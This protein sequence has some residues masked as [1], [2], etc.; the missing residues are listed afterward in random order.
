MENKQVFEG[1]RGEIESRLPWLNGHLRKMLADLVSSVLREPTSNTH[2]LS[3]VLPRPIQKN[4]HRYQV[5]RRF[6]SNPR[7]EPCKIM[8]PFV[9]DVVKQLGNKNQTIVIQMDQSQLANG[10]EV[11][12]ISLRLGER[13]LPIGWKV[14]KTGGNIGFNSQQELL[15][16]MYE[17]LPKEYQYVLMADRFYGTKMLIQWCQD[18]DFAYRIRLK[19]NLLFEHEDAIITP[20]D[21]QVTG[22][23][24]VEQV[25]FHDAQTMTNIGVL[26]EDNHP[27]PWFIAM[28]CKPSE[29]RTRD[30]GMR[31]GIEAMFSDFKSRGFG[32]TESHLQQAD[33]FERLI[34]ILS[35]ALYWFVSLGM[36]AV[37]QE[38]HRQSSKKKESIKVISFYAGDK[39]LSAPIALGH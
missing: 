35:L 37:H 1:I 15:D 29:Y 13:A 39:I 38:T 19:G 2:V 6:L 7:I 21:F 8:A 17:I 24:G 12:M 34:L 36:Y 26:Y 3:E 9:I 32:I 5:I 20:Q 25:R 27:E 18:H 4:V 30:Y 10:F 28:D 31:W 11:L 14:E 23:Y 22:N 33:R 16:S